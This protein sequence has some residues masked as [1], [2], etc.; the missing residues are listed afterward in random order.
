MKVVHSHEA[1]LFVAP[2]EHGEVYHPE[3]CELVFVAEAE[4]ASHFEAQLAQ[5]LAGAHGVVAA[6]NEDEVARLG[7]HSL[8]EFLEYFLGVEFIY[9]RFHVSVLFHAG[10]NHALG[11]NLGLLHKVGEGVELLAGIIGRPLGADTSD[12]CGIVEYAE[13]MA[14]EGGEK[15]DSSIT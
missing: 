3:T 7:A 2:F 13:A 14:F 6:E 5:L 11:A 8:S 9:A 15:T 1:L 4:L 12:I 10:V